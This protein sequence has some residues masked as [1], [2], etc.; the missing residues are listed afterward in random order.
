MEEREKAADQSFKR[1]SKSLQ[2]KDVVQGEFLQYLEGGGLCLQGGGA[3]R[4]VYRSPRLSRDLDFVYDDGA[5][6]LEAIRAAERLR[7]IKGYKTGFRDGELAR[8]KIQIPMD[9][10]SLVLN[11]EMYQ[12]PAYKKCPAKLGNNTIHVESPIELAADKIVALLDIFNRRGGVSFT[13]VYDIAFIERNNKVSPDEQ[14]R[15]LVRK[16]MERYGLTVDGPY[17]VPPRKVAELKGQL[18]TKKEDMFQMLVDYFYVVPTTDI[19]P[20]VNSVIRLLD[21]LELEAMLS[22]RNG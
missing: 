17:R 5:A 19:E 18:A 15:E 13:N 14:L 12:A 22:G 7:E 1:P 20:S 9:M 21:E 8:V 2:A 11:I 16:K 6:K 3:L 10:T 4:H